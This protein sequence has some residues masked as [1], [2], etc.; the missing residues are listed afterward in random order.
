MQPSRRNSG[1]QRGGG[2]RTSVRT[3][4]YGRRARRMSNVRRMPTT[5]RM[6]GGRRMGGRRNMVSGRRNMLVNGGRV[7][8]RTNMRNGM[9]TRSL[10]HGRRNA[11]SGRRNQGFNV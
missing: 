5:G 8:T 4:L 1:Y 9:R 7:A 6:T 10:Y 11:V 2:V 3:G